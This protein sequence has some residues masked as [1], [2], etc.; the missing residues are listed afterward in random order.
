MAFDKI[1]DH[2]NGRQKIKLTDALMALMSGIAVFSL[3]CPSLLKFDEMKNEKA[4]RHNLRTLY[5]IPG[6]PCDTQLHSILDP[7]K[8][9]DLEPAVVALHQAA[10]K[11]GLFKKYEY[12]NGRALIYRSI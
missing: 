1:K 5:G 6:A 9:A 2:R 10:D 12:F 8:P 7:V 4:I 11:A 3:K